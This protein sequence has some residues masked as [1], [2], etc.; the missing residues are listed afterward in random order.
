MLRQTAIVSLFFLAVGCIE[1]YEYQHVTDTSVEGQETRGADGIADILP[2]DQAIS[3]ADTLPE[4]LADLLPDVAHD[5]AHDQQ[6]SQVDLELPDLLD[7]EIP[8]IPEC[9]DLECGDDGCGGSCGDCDDSN[10]CS[11]D[12]CIEG[13]CQHENLSGNECKDPNPCTAMEGTC[14]DGAC[15]TVQLPLDTIANVELCWC[16]EDTDCALFDLDMCD[17]VGLICDPELDGADHPHCLYH[18]VTPLDCSDGIDCTI[19]DCEAAVGCTHAS[20]DQAC[21]NEDPCTQGKC[22]E[23]GCEQQALSDVSCDDLNACTIGDTCQEGQC[24]PGSSSPDCDDTIGC[25]LDQCDPG[26]GCLHTPDESACDDGNPCT[27]DSCDAE[28]DCLHTNNNDACS[29]DDPCTI[30]D[31]CANGECG[32]MPVLCDDQ[33]PCTIDQCNPD[34]GECLSVPVADDPP[35]ACDAS[36]DVCS[37]DAGECVGGTCIASP[38]TCDDANP[39]TDDSCGLTGCTF[40]ANDLPCDDNDKCTNGDQCAGGLCLP[41]PTIHV[42]CL[43]YDHDGI[44]NGD[45]SCPLAF[46]GDQLD[47]DG[48]SKPDACEPLAGIQPRQRQLNLLAMGETPTARRTAEIVDVPLRNSMVDHA[49]RGYFPLN[50]DASQPYEQGAGASLV[51]ITPTQGAFGDEGGAVQ[52]NGMDSAIV[53]PVA[54]L[55]QQASI[56]LW[57]R[58]DNGQSFA[59]GG[60]DASGK[61]ARLVFNANSK[62]VGVTLQSSPADT[63]VLDSNTTLGALFDG[64]WHHLC[65]QW[66]IDASAGRLYLDSALHGVTAKVTGN[67]VMTKVPLV[68]WHLGAFYDGNTGT[69]GEYFKGAADDM[70]ACGRWLTQREIEVYFKSGQP[71]GSTIVPDSQADFDDVRI[72]D[73]SHEEG[74][75]VQRSRIIGIRPHSN[76]PCPNGVSPTLWPHRDDLCGVVAHWPLGPSLESSVGN[77]H[78]T[79]P[80]NNQSLQMGRFGDKDGSVIV[81]GSGG[82]L[83]SA[84]ITAADQ[85]SD[86]DLTIELWFF[87]KPG[88]LPGGYLLGMVKTNGTPI[89]QLHVAEEGT[90]TWSL[91]TTVGQVSLA[92]QITPGTWNH[93]ALTYDG[94]NAT[95]YLNGLQAQSKALS[96]SVMS[97]NQPF[98]VG[99]G[100]SGGD[101]EVKAIIDDILVHDVA[102][103][104]DYLFY[105]ARPELPTVRFLAN[106]SVENQGTDEAPLFAPRDYR[107]AWGDNKAHII[108]PYLSKQDGTLCHALTNR[109]LGLLGWWDFSAVNDG[110]VVDRATLH[111]SALLHGPATPSNGAD[112]TSLTLGTNGYLEVPYTPLMQTP[113][114][115][116]EVLAAATEGTL[117]S[118]GM[119]SADDRFN[120][121]LAIQEQQVLYSEFETSDETIVKAV[122]DPGVFAPDTFHAAVTSFDG[123]TLTAAVDGTEVLMA[124]STATPGQT[125]QPLWIGATK[126]GNGGP[127]APLLGSLDNVRIWNRALKP[128]EV[129]QFPRLSASPGPFL[130]GDGAPLDTDDDGILDDGDDS[131][132]I[133]DH[134]CTGGNST[135]CD[136]N[137]AAVANPDQADP[138]GDGI[139]SV[140]DNCP[141]ISNQDQADHNNDGTGNLCDPIYL[142]DWDHDG[143]IGA[144]DP[145]P[146]AFDGDNADYDGD[147]FPDACKPFTESYSNGQGLAFQLGEPSD[148]RTS[149][150]VVEVPL[151]AGLLDASTLL[152]LT[153]EDQV[154]HDQSPNSMAGL[155]LVGGGGNPVGGPN[156]LGNAISLGAGRCVLGPEPFTYPLRQFTIMTWVQTDQSCT[157]FDNG[158]VTQSGNTTARGMSLY[159]NSA[160][161]LHLVFGDA[162]ETVGYVDANFQ[163]WVAW[164]WHHVAV[165]FYMGKARIYVDGQLH[166]TTDLSSQF[167]ALTGDNF[168]L[169]IGCDNAN[170]AAGGLNLDDF[171][172]FN[173]TLSTQEIDD[174]FN[175]RR[176]YGAS[177]VP[178]AQADFDDVRI[179]EF[180]FDDDPGKEFVTRSRIVGV[181]RH[182]DSACPQV[183]PEVILPDREDLCGVNAYW[184]LDDLSGTE[185]AQPF[186]SPLTAQFASQPPFLAFGRFGSPDGAMRFTNR[187]QALIVPTAQALSPDYGSVSLEFW[188]RL[189]DPSQGSVLHPIVRKSMTGT[190]GYQVSYSVSNGKISCEWFGGSGKTFVVPANTSNK[191]AQWHHVGCVLERTEALILGRVYLD[192]LLDNEVATS[193]NFLLSLSND[194]PLRIG[195]ANNDSDI[196]LELD[197]VIYHAV[198]KSTDYFFNRTHPSVPRLRFLANSSTADKSN[199]NTPNYPVRGYEA[200][201]GKPGE[202]AMVPIVAQP[203]SNKLCYGLVNECLGYVG[204]WRFDNVD[205]SNILDSGP[206]HNHGT[207]TGSMVWR[208]VNGQ[209]GLTN[210]GNAGSV[211]IL[212][213]P[214]L[215]QPRGTWEA[216]FRPGVDIDSS[217][218]NTMALFRRWSGGPT[219]GYA[220]ALVSDGRLY[221]NRH[222]DDNKTVNLYS[223]KSQWFQEQT[224]HAAFSAGDGNNSMAVNYTPE[225]QTANASGGFGAESATLYFGAADGTTSFF[226]GSFF[227]FRFMSRVLAPDEYLRRVPVKVQ[228]SN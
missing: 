217:L 93:A 172:I 53:F 127:V 159:H 163:P 140:V 197:E 199:D 209:F 145:C 176:P 228:F 181:R 99:G 54:E 169:S 201:W 170:G 192:G 52:F 33:N 42:D 13:L 126:G 6:D 72:L 20:N 138:D 89:T 32:G 142:S 122:S 94:T 117:A 106:T 220:T 63:F 131:G 103:T 37:V 215:N 114:Y 92:G 191:D 193:G 43:D 44:V 123:T 102:K 211:S 17:N 50:G 207:A 179:M 1:H 38:I 226:N 151:Q 182:S 23:S 47:L 101:E 60:M 149:N 186:P 36:D 18:A 147:S 98:Y 200:K 156:G 64:Q 14:I 183:S 132:T 189:P 188:Y 39:C 16:K 105:R 167:T 77:Y 198:A 7:E 113:N 166:K 180:P 59:F 71:F 70:V 45:D 3:P 227:E 160:G 225:E 157:L 68:N 130:G 46:D 11:S 67:P 214:K 88:D 133:G 74:P 55:G 185:I 104:P 210:N 152:H 82:A 154:V 48:N 22:G 164:D 218:P 30:D 116:L 87:T 95:L 141:E 73:A 139:G 56:C 29:D 69:A 58:S 213:H 196:S 174:Y 202:T 148:R 135:N 194:E 24:Q 177:M 203:N 144:D 97:T 76:S 129:Q 158:T 109:C 91:A 31:I 221:F 219:N 119:A 121:R 51:A 9:T 184:P 171:L 96:G 111:L 25:T 155:N 137:A 83:Q 90:L 80:Y 212:A 208:Y 150:E 128:D 61:G 205:R 206:F 27:Q 79:S 8:C 12:S 222:G 223:A 110:L 85:I 21:D 204:W 173:R 115:T 19:D 216:V 195:W 84:T 86:E 65:M 66:D 143:L 49:S 134:P 10:D 41:G 26:T 136:D 28:K 153:F 4:L 190:E 108:A 187:S 40:V 124:E 2:A 162:S 62:A 35:M 15:D 112:G 165:T 5:V 120:Y 107:L 81:Y 175:A 57:L 78:L 125:Q 100:G 75:R 146:F 118:R 34:D 161:A 224:Y 178:E 168:G